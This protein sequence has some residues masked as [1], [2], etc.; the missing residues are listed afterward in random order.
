MSAPESEF[1][2][3]PLIETV[4]AVQYAPI[5]GLSSAHIGIFWGSLGQCFHEEHS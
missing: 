4:L 3:P 1:K 2:N 5:K